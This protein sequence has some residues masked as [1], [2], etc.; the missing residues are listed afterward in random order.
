MSLFTFPSIPLSG[1]EIYFAGTPRG[2]LSRM[3]I[4]RATA[5]ALTDGGTEGLVSSVF[6]SSVVAGLA[7]ILFATQTPLAR[8]RSFDIIESIRGGR[9]DSFFT[10]KGRRRRVVQ[11]FTKKVL[12]VMFLNQSILFRLLAFL[13]GREG[14]G[15]S[16]TFCLL[17]V[18]GS[19]S[20]ARTPSRWRRRWRRRRRP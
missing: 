20:P 17:S 10:R 7:R 1:K 18:C 16:V 9:K 12:S 13:P 11:G 2:R 8:S 15:Y 14:S 3:R 4:F 6:A 19:S 5:V